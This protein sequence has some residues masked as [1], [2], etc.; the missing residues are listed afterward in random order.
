MVTAKQQIADLQKQKDAAIRQRDSRRTQ[1]AGIELKDQ[2]SRDAR[3]ELLRG[4]NLDNLRATALQTA[5][6]KIRETGSPVGGVSGFVRGQVQNRETSLQFEGRAKGFRLDLEKEFGVEEG[7]KI[8]R[9]AKG[10][11]ASRMKAEALLNVPR[12]RTIT[13][14]PSQIMSFDEQ[15]PNMSLAPPMPDQMGLEFG[16]IKEDKRRNFFGDV[17][18]FVT[19]TPRK[20][21]SF[22][23]VLELHLRYLQVQ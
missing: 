22:Y 3:R 13:N 14:E 12:Q 20:I 7:R 1:A 10:G 9:L 21:A 8:F 15:A 19:F 4:S 5:I 17:A 18:S 11:S 23:L 16:T 2:G 6:N